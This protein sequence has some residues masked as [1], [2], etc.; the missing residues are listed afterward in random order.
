MGWGIVVDDATMALLRCDRGT[1]AG[2]SSTLRAC[3]GR[4]LTAVNG[5]AVRRA[6]E[7]AGAATERTTLRLRFAAA[8]RCAGLP[9]ALVSLLCRAGLPHC[10]PLLAAGGFSGVADGDVAPELTAIGAENLI[11]MGPASESL[12][13]FS[14]Q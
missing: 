6:A 5:A 7:A 14:G 3:V 9:A 2:R 11:G 8:P 10:A 12:D 13:D 1:V 4:R